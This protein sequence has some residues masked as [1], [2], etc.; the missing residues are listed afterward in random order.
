MNKSARLGTSVLS[1]SHVGMVGVSRATPWT[2]CVNNWAL[3]VLAV[4][5]EVDGGASCLRGGQA[6][7]RESD[8]ALGA[9]ECVRVCE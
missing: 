3:L 6:Q 2:C 9:C 7:G 1:G 8:G 5:A 4:P